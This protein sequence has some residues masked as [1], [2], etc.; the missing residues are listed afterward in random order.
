[1]T[2]DA[3]TEVLYRM[4]KSFDADYFYFELLGMAASSITDSWRQKD[5]GR[6]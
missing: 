5:L 4:R 2:S 1:M 6:S 3:I